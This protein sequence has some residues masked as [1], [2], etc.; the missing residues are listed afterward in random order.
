MAPPALKP[1]VLVVDDSAINRTA[2]EAVLEGDFSVTLAESGAQAIEKCRTAEFAVIV[3]DVRM[4]GM[5]GFDTAKALRTREATRAT[6]IIIFTS[7]YDQNLAQIT[8]GFSA[9]ATDFLFTPVE[10]D[11][12]KIK[13]TT[14]AQIYLRHEALRMQVQE[15]QRAI[16]EL[17]EELKRRGQAVT[18]VRE[19]LDTV[20]RKASEIDRDT[21]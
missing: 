3:L 10:P 15:L 1:R 18:T 14:Y 12:L 4:P 17:R 21:Q 11:L 8:R 6:P 20:E 16:V 19:R 2:F 7:A 13:V 9:G 5:D